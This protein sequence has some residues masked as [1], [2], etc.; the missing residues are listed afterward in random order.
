MLYQNGVENKT[1]N[2]AC[3]GDLEYDPR[4]S[5]CIEQKMSCVACF[6]GSIGSIVFWISMLILLWIVLWCILR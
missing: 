6:D 4:A 1:G 5:L 3:I 2:C